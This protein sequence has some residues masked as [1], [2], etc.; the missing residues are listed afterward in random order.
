MQIIRTY[1]YH[2]AHPSNEEIKMS[3]NGQSGKA[4]ALDAKEII[5]NYTRQEETHDIVTCEVRGVDCN[6]LAR[7]HTSAAWA[8]RS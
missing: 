8:L 1:I 5:L 6:Q 4:H 3:N 2:E 7:R